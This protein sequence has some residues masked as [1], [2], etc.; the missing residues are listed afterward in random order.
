MEKKSSLFVILGYLYL[1]I[2]NLIFVIGWCNPPTAIICSI[3]LLYGFYFLCKNAPELWVPESRKERILLLLVFFIAFL[4]VYLAGIGGFSF[5]NFD[6]TYRNEIFE[7]LAD[8]EWPV[9]INRYYCTMVYY[10]GFWMPAALITKINGEFILGYFVQLLWATFGVFLVFYYIL[11]ALKKKVLWPIFL[12]IFFSGMDIIGLYFFNKGLYATFFFSSLIETWAI[13]HIFS[14]M[15]YL[16]FWVFNQALPAWV[17]TFLLLHQKNNKNIIFLMVILLIFSTL[18]AFGATPFALYFC[19]KNGEEDLR[20]I[21]TFSH[22]KKAICSAL[23]FPNI[24]ALLFLFPVIYLY[25]AHNFMYGTFGMA[26]ELHD[27]IIQEGEFALDFDRIW[28]YIRFFILEAGILIFCLFFYQKKNPLLYIVFITLVS[29]AFLKIGYGMDFE[30]RTS[31]PALVFLFYLTVKTLQEC[32]LNRHKIIVSI[33]LI[34][35]AI[36]TVTPIQE[37]GRIYKQRKF[38]TDVR[39]MKIDLTHVPPNMNFFG[40]IYKNT[41]LKYFGKQNEKIR[42]LNG[43]VEKLAEEQKRA[44]ARERE[45]T[46][47]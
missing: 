28:K 29:G 39:A 30:M 10:I 31:I 14:S 11:A 8:R 40:R 44:R 47:E 9:V 43:A 17:F 32:D 13:P 34:F 3:V 42:V 24:S 41:F 35:L 16:L 23:S 38:Q 25:F 15:T 37:F 46:K 12:F 2:P 5:Q 1:I 6:H 36:G 20:K 27:T 33:M 21:L 19:L 7:L 45:K 26:S 18:P 22:I 4:W